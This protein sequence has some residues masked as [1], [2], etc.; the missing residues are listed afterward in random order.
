M[1]LFYNHW[2]IPF[3]DKIFKDFSIICEY[4]LKVHE[5]EYIND[6]F[7]KLLLLRNKKHKYLYFSHFKIWY[8]CTVYK[9]II[10][11]IF[12]LNYF[13]CKSKQSIKTLLPEEEE[14]FWY[15]EVAFL[16]IS[17]EGQQQFS[18]YS[19]KTK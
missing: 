3:A 2:W 14:G 5:A 13:Y 10:S 19:W 4:I 18:K 9:C 15:N 17:K 16:F 7:A 12:Y 8:L 6:Y 1:S 11:H